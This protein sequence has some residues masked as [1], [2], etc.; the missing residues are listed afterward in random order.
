M[1]AQQTDV[2]VI[3]AGS[4]LTGLALA[5]TLNAVRPSLR[6]VVTDPTPLPIAGADAAIG[7][8]VSAL[9]PGSIAN[10]AAFG[11]WSSMP[12]SHYQNYTDMRVW[13]AA[14]NCGDGIHF[15]A[16]KFGVPQLG[17]IA[18]N[19]A[20][21]ATLY[22]HC[23]AQS[24]VSFEPCAVTRVTSMPAHTAIT[25]TD[26]SGQ[27]RELSAAL[28]VGADG[29]NSAVRALAGIASVGWAH[30]QRALVAH[31]IPEHS[32]QMTALQRFLPDGPLALLP[33]PNDRVSLVLSTTPAEA[34][35]LSE[36]DASDFDA[37]I[38]QASDAV[39]GQLTLD[40]ARASFVLESRYAKDPIAPRCVVIG[41][42]AH[43]VHPL[44]GQGANLGFS[45]VAVLARV[46]DEALSARQD[47][48]DAPVLRRYRRAR[49][50]DN[51]STLYG[52]DW[53]NR[54]FARD[55]GIIADSRR[56][57]MRWF[58]RVGIVKHLAAGHAMRAA[59]LP[60]G[61]RS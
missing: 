30:Q 39:L 42:A 15:S 23:Q 46:V 45:D 34:H 40:S 16:A 1:G 2:D 25:L 5:A 53:V 48:G 7:L 35:R 10:F 19:A 50:V 33:L 27:A 3:I 8:R 43:A 13:D 21:R 6:I 60:R 24:H 56:A 44:A 4:G 57:G 28:L 22:Q 26:T 18:D 54:L 14:M 37:H 51:V 52:L 31:L 12:A 59:S 11:V 47:I 29:R 32:H 41:D 17:C 58:D 38:T 49:M 61:L 20:L 36:I 9:T 55:S